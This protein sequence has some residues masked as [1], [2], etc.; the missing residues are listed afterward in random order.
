M[1][2]DG[3]E[4]W[5][6][7][8][9]AGYDHGARRANKWSAC[10]L[11]VPGQPI[12]IVMTSTGTALVSCAGSGEVVAF[13]ARNRRRTGRVTVDVQLPAGAGARAGAA[14]ATG[15]VPVGISIAGDGTVFVAATRAD[16]VVALALPALTVTRTIDVPGEPDGMALTPIMP[17]AV[18]HACEAP[19]DPYA[20]G[21]A[22]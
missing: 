13:D 17:Q 8:R 6:A 16:K 20:P 11:T 10:T 7:A 12:R 4:V 19:A 21:E 14:S 3:R 5:V 15:A 2:R 1:T 18:C 22:D 9:E